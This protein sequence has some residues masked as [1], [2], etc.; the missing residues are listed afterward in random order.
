MPGRV[1]YEYLVKQIYNTKRQ[2]PGNNLPWN[3]SEFVSNA[4]G[5]E[6]NVSESQQ[7]HTLGK[8]SS[9]AEYNK[10]I[11]S[12]LKCFKVQRQRNENVMS[13][14]DK[15]WIMNNWTGT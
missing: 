7:L 11:W 12:G 6:H 4:I 1:F 10:V 9:R 5:K 8:G 2:T 3:S 14:I 15:I 13:F